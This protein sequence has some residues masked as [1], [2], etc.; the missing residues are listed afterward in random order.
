MFNFMVFDD[1][2]YTVLIPFN[3]ACFVEFDK[4]LFTVILLLYVHGFVV[5][6]S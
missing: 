5:F 4:E 1:E 2:M 3:C 6:L